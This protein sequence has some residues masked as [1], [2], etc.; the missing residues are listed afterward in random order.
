MKLLR[1]EF[2]LASGQFKDYRVIVFRRVFRNKVEEIEGIVVIFHC[3]GNGLV[4]ETVDRFLFTR[5]FIFIEN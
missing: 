1:S 4:T 5:F 3:H 2:V